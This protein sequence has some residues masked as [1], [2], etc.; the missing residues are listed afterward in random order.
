MNFLKSFS[1][2]LLAFLCSKSIKRSVMMMAEFLA[3]IAA[4]SSDSDEHSLFR[5]EQSRNKYPD[6]LWWMCSPSDDEHTLTV[7]F[8]RARLLPSCSLHAGRAGS[9]RRSWSSC[10]NPQAEA[11]LHAWST[12]CQRTCFD[13]STSTFGFWLANLKSRSTSIYVI[14]IYGAQ[15]HEDL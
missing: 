11:K 13:M 9:A 10:M 5:F 1:N 15:M 2:F 3:E 8:L 6:V 12:S 4:E 14:Y 7:T